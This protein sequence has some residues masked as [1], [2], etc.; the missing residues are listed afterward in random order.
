MR[1]SKKG[2]VFL[3]LALMLSA[4]ILPATTAR[5]ARTIPT[6]AKQY[7]GHFYYGYN[8]AS[9]WEDAKAKCE[10]YGGHLATITSAKENQMVFQAL[11]ES[12]AS[13]AYFGFY[14]EDAESNQWKWVT[15]EKVSYHNWASGQPDNYNGWGEIY[16][17]MDSENNGAWSDVVRGVSGYVCEW[18]GYNIQ[19]NEK[20]LEMKPGESTFLQCAVEDIDGNTVN[21]TV[22]WKS[23]NVKVAKVSSKGKVVAVDP[24]S[25]KITCKV[26]DSKKTV[27]VVVLPRQV[28]SL[29]VMG[30]NTGSI[31]LKW[32][33]QTGVTGYMV[34]RYDPDLEEFTKVKTVKGSFNT[35]TIQGL[36]KGTTYSFKV[37]AYVKSG[38]KTYF[39]DYS[40][41]C[42]VKTK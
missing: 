1:K 31:Q 39:G 11:Q 26:G 4:C 13:W 37:R 36:K 34:Y 29:S 12:G 32:K 33:K 20:N 5:A 19:I 14:R 41:V 27:K 2:L 17:G 6:G 42:K 28:S 25:C 23:D 38:S 40:K 15:G 35:A 18:D 21:K 24:G 7:R 8:D 10:S 16:A 30:R 9:S 3:M 22:S